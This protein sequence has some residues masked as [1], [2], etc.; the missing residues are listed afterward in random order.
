MDDCFHLAIFISLQK[1]CPTFWATVFPQQKLC[2]NFDKKTDW[3]TTWPIFSLTHLVTLH[4][5]DV[6]IPPKL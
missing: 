2:I 3:A 1:S 5:D 6:E 4:G